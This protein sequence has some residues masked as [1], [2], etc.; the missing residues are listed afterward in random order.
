MTFAPADAPPAVMSIDVEDWFHVENLRPVIRRD[1][2]SEQQLRVEQNVDR[3]LQ[4]MA[5]F[6][7]GV[8]C[9]FFVLGWVA[10]RCPD[11]VRRIADAGHEIASHGYGHDLLDSL[12]PEAFRADVE[13]SKGLLEDIAG[14]EVRGYRAPSFSIKEWAIPILQSVGFSYDSSLFPSVGHDRYGNLAGIGPDQPVV[15]VSPG[16]FEIGVSCVTIASRGFPWGG[17]GYFRLLPYRVFRRGARRILRSGR[18]YVFYIHPWEIDP[19]QPR[20]EGLPRSYEFRH[21]VGLGRCEAR[22][23]SLLA[24]FEWTTMADL[25]ERWSAPRTN[26]MG[27]F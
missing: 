23:T 6:H 13:R 4:L 10:D 14:A 11:L 17:G 7:G 9:T 26:G 5:S 27:D 12:S 15:E 8:R 22:F 3:M 25:L 18:P 24:D 1:T 16:F 2:W 19:D 21:Y 20:V